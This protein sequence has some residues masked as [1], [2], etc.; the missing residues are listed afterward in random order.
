MATWHSR[1]FEDYSQYLKAHYG[2]I[3]FM[4]YVFLVLKCLNVSEEASVDACSREKC[5]F[6]VN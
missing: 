6:E 2:T 5:L 3:N 4:C 1:D